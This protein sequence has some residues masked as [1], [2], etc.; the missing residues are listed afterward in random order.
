MRVE[1]LERQSGDSGS[2]HVVCCWWPAPW[3]WRRTDERTTA[4][5]RTRLRSS[6]PRREESMGKGRD[7]ERMLFTA[8]KVIATA[9]RRC[10]RR[11]NPAELA[12]FYT[13]A[14]QHAPSTYLIV[15]QLDADQRRSERSAPSP[16][17]PWYVCSCQFRTIDAL[18][19]ASGDI[20]RTAAT[21]GHYHPCQG[22]RTRGRPRPQGHSGGAIVCLF[23]HSDETAMT[24]W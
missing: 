15:L 14:K 4:R 19:A 17:E 5:D 24:K 20:L 16:A 9:E 11:P 3:D 23:S 1:R 8:P 21:K 10:S 18:I 22:M 7:A 2:G 6:S 13:P 12:A